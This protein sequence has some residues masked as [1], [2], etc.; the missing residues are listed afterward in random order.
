MRTCDVEALRAAGIDPATIARALEFSPIKS[1]MKI[2]VGICPACGSRPL[3]GDFVCG[4]CSELYAGRPRRFW[5]HVYDRADGMTGRPIYPKPG[6][7][8]LP[9]QTPKPVVHKIVPV[10]AVDA[11]ERALEFFEFLVTCGLVGRVI[12]AQTPAAAAR[13]AHVLN[14]DGPTAGHSVLCLGRT[15][16]EETEAVVER[17]EP[18]KKVKLVEHVFRVEGPGYTRELKL[19]AVAS[20]DRS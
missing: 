17:T 3:S 19:A 10:S 9:A 7:Q 2:K 13:T 16:Q 12:V 11:P 14:E 15:S 18:K 1:R 8:Q 5:Q 20:P 4:T 6:P